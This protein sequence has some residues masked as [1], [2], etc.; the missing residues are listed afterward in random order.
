MVSKSELKLIKKAGFDT[1]DGGKYIIVKSIGSA[2]MAELFIGVDKDSRMKV[3]LKIFTKLTEAAEAYFLNEEKAL[4][5]LKA[6]KQ[7]PNLYGSGR[8]KLEK[9]NGT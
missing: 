1:V 4:K 5:K 2:D 7:V 6:C 3:A 8:S 9:Q